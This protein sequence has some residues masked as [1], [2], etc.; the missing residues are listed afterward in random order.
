MSKEGKYRLYRVTRTDETLP[1]LEPINLGIP[2]LD[3]GKFPWL[4]RLHPFFDQ[5]R[6]MEEE[7]KGGKK[8]K[9]KKRG[10]LF[11]VGETKVVPLTE[12]LARK[13]VKNRWRVELRDTGEPI[14]NWERDLIA[15]CERRHAEM[16]AA[17]EEVL[18]FTSPRGDYVRAGLVGRYLKLAEIG[19][20][21]ERLKASGIVSEEV[22]DAMISVAA[23]FSEL[24]SGLESK[25]WKFDADGTV[26]EPPKKGRRARYPGSA[27]RAHFRQLEKL[28]NMSS[29]SRDFVERIRRDLEPV[30]GELSFSEVREA[31]K[32]EQKRA[33]R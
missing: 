24:K 17:R 15:V 20:D 5:H 33:S 31:M 3:P 18:S 13:L 6:E 14:N 4:R 21:M 30:L 7:L 26:W 27:I 23:R 19:D 1:S 29:T 28:Y 22:A 11:D 16:E 10:I 25:G 8:R 32:Y 12:D 2:N 9:F